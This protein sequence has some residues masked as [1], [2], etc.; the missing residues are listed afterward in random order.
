[1][2]Y[3]MKPTPAIS[4]LFERLVNETGHEQSLLMSVPQIRDGLTGKISR[5]TYL[6]YLAQA[7]HHVKHTVPLMQWTKACL[8]PNTTVFQ[9]ALDDYVSEET[10]HEEWILNDIRAAG[11]DAEAVRASAPL[12]ATEFM[13]SYAYDY[14][15]RINPLGFFGMVFVLEGTSTQ[16]A[17]QGADAVMKSLDLPRSAFTYLFSHGALDLEHM[18]FFAKLMASVTAQSDQDAIIHMAKRMFVLFANVFASIPHAAEHT[19]ES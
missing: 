18:N 17:S 8:P 15:S 16:I 4:S 14:I 11:G 12:P 2:P 1:M 10:G 9:D 19:H 3:D 6:A 7:Y 13:V 5:Q